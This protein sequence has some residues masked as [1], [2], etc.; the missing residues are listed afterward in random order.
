MSRFNSVLDES[1]DDL[2]TIEE[3]KT[4]KFEPKGEKNGENEMLKQIREM[5]DKIKQS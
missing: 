3:E 2:R 4:V 1:K 5:E